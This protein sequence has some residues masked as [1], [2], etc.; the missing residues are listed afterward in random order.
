MRTI[1]AAAK[2]YF[3]LRSQRSQRFTGFRISIV[4]PRPLGNGDLKFSASPDD[5]PGVRPD[6]VSA[7]KYSHRGL[8]D[9]GTLAVLNF[10]RRPRPLATVTYNF[11]PRLMRVPRREDDPSR[12]KTGYSTL[13]SQRSQRFTGF[14][15]SIFQSFDFGL[16]Q[17]SP[18]IFV[19]V[20]ISPKEIIL[21]DLCDLYVNAFF[22]KTAEITRRQ[23]L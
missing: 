3:T 22:P 7:K 13:R 1:R 6:P 21:C 16:G 23:H 18:K 9:R 14:R 11:W 5:G 15:I 19:G 12:G 17:R 20:S 4:R 10:N 2:R 8:K